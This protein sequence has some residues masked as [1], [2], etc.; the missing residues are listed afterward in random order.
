MDHVKDR[1]ARTVRYK[2][3][4]CAG[5]STS[6]A[7][8]TASRNGS[9]IRFVYLVH[10]C[11]Q[12]ILTKLCKAG[13][14]IA[15]EPLSTHNVVYHYVPPGKTAKRVCK[16]ANNPPEQ[17]CHRHRKIVCSAKTPNIRRVHA[18]HTE[19]SMLL[20]V[21]AVHKWSKA[22]AMPASERWHVSAVFQAV[23]GTLESYRSNNWKLMCIEH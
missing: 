15:T 19:T 21:T 5:C 9:S 6:C 13:V 12:Q 20:Q 2:L 7:K 3:T 1:A 18:L 16:R 17:Q 14:T 11:E 23:V 4:V 22:T 10:N 8:W